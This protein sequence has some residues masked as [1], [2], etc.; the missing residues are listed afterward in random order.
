M[1]M[2]VS[3][4]AEALD[5]TPVR[6]RQLIDAGKL[7]AD[8]VG[9]QWVLEEMEVQR[10]RRSPRGRPSSPSS[11]WGYLLYLDERSRWEQFED[12]LLQCRSLPPANPR[13]FQRWQSWADQLVRHSPGEDAIISL[14]AKVDSRA[15]RCLFAADRA[16][17]PDLRSDPRLMLTGVSHPASTLLSNS[18]VEAYIDDDDV[19]R[20]K[21]DFF[22]VPAKNERSAN[23]ILHVAEE[24]PKKLPLAA[25]AADLAEHNGPR[26][27]NEAARILRSILAH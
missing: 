17:I 20:L 5:I 23:V 8:R 6:V 9:K 10:Y 12:E 26:E 19:E 18:E 7:K 16:D 15:E 13:M 14:L 2:S 25:V 11:A 27:K 4:A 21:K 1:A 3:E 24:L 22:L